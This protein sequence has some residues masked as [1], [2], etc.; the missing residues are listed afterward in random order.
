MEKS[1]RLL[2]I[3]MAAALALSIL[4][5]ATSCGDK[6]GD[7]GGEGDGT[8]GNTGTPCNH[9]DLNHD[10]MCDACG[11]DY[12]EP[13]R[14]IELTVTVVDERNNP[15]TGL[16]ITVLGDGDR[17]GTGKTDANGQFKVLADP[18]E[19]SV[20]VDGLPQNWFTG[21]S[22]IDLSEERN[23][24][25]IT[26]VDNTPDGS[27]GK[28]F[29]IGDD[30]ATFTIPAGA[31]FNFNVRGVNRTLKVY[32]TN[33]K[34]IYDGKEYLANEDGIVEVLIA[35]T[36]DTYSTTPFVIENL[37]NEENSV[38]VHFESPIGSVA[39][40]YEATLDT[41]ATVSVPKDETVYY[42]WIATADGVLTL[43]AESD[44]SS[45]MLY[46]Y[47]T[48]AVTGY[49]DGKASVYLP[50]NE[51]DEISIPVA[52]TAQA[53]VNEVIFKI[54]LA[55]ASE[56]SP[57]P[58]TVGRSTLKFSTGTT[59][60]YVYSGEA[61]NAT[62]PIDY[63]TVAVNGVELEPDFTDYMIRFTLNDGDVIAITNTAEGNAEIALTIT[64][65]PKDSEV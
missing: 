61:A 33:A 42:S 6:G 23:T 40:P 7:E 55:A 54:S 56:D 24:L 63:V 15:L 30:E 48:Y 13:D 31:R 27:V 14:R 35:G 21:V 60:Y 65:Q 34:V 51:G 3:I 29:F 57:L 2:A 32:N 20:L 39:N 11:E 47:T 64:A 26:A 38:R 45:I 36:S 9:F 43:T 28:P 1:R 19:Y 8:G 5:V 12:T 22:N 52:S 16:D 10:N 41:S 4:F 37:S 50:V 59:Y 17:V 18:G 25:R 58:V 44:G 62:V 49:T 46:N 53:D